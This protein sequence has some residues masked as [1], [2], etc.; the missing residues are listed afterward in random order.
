MDH[1]EDNK[2]IFFYISSHYFIAK[3]I[4]F[5]EMAVSVHK[6]SLILSVILVH[7][8][9]SD[10]ITKLGFLCRTANTGVG[11]PWIMWLRLSISVS[12]LSRESVIYAMCHEGS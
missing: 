3:Y 7:K 8:V 10:Q 11:T 2:F 9:W 5:L 12:N 4:I 6:N 1:A